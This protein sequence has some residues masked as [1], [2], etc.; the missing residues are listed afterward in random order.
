MNKTNHLALKSFLKQRL[1]K[2]HQ[3]WSDQHKWDA[4]LSSAT[5]IQW[6]LKTSKQRVRIGLESPN[7]LSFLVFSAQHSSAVDYFDY[8][9]ANNAE[10]VLK[11][12]M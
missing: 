3:D 6:K 10:E 11:A 8:M 12:L 2:H 4:T 5:Q 9:G 7:H 1:V